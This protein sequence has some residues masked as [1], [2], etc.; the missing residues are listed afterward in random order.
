MFSCRSFRQT[1]R[2][3]KYFPGTEFSERNKD[4]D[5]P[6]LELSPPPISSPGTDRGG[7]MYRTDPP[8]MQ[9]PNQTGEG[10]VLQRVVMGEMGRVLVFI[11][12]IFIIQRQSN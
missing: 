11:I 3:F 1:D 9:H 12:A 7:F 6:P 5:P 2:N 4:T 8:Q 10:L